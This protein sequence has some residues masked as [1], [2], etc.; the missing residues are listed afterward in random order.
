MCRWSFEWS[1]HP[2]RAADR[3]IRVGGE[4]IGSKID[5]W[6]RR[7]SE[8]IRAFDVVAVSGLENARIPGFNA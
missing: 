4:Q 6:A 7:S 1:L 8:F 2:T 5:R 3:D